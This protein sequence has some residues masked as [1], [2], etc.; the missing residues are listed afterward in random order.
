MQINY[1]EIR[2]KKTTRA[3]RRCHNVTCHFVGTILAGSDLTSIGEPVSL[4]IQM[5]VPDKRHY[6]RRK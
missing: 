1:I 3:P 4:K 2:F 5:G 6:D